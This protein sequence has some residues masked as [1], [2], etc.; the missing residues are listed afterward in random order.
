MKLTE[1]QYKLFLKTRLDTKINYLSGVENKYHNKKVIY[2]GIKF[3]SI[4]E[5]NHYI[6]LKQLEKAGII[7]DL[8]LQVPFLLIDTIRHN[9]KTYPK[10]KYIADFTYKRDGKL[11]V[12]DVKSEITRKDKT[13]RLK[14]KILLDK[15]KDIIFKEII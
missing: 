11:Y 5:K 6:A 9:D 3:D 2:N 14:I 7:S 4:R 8:Q 15:Y 13:Y 1:K 12:E 10:T